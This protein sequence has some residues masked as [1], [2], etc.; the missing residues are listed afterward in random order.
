MNELG[1]KPRDLLVLNM[2]KYAG[3]RSTLAG[4]HLKAGDTSTF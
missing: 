2:L 4:P 3:S 1:D